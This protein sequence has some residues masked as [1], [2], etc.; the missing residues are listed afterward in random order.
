MLDLHKSTVTGAEWQG[1]SQLSVER[2][3]VETSRE[4]RG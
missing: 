2:V 3:R 4:P 1:E